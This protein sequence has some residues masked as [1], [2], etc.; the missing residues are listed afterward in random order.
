MQYDDNATVSDI[1]NGP[2]V[3]CVSEGT[4][5]PGTSLTYATFG[6]YNAMGQPATLTLGNGVQ[7]TYSYATDSGGAA[8]CQTGSFRLCTIQAT[9]GGSTLQNLAYGYDIE[10]NVA[11]VGHTVGAI[12]RVGA[13]TRINW[14]H[15]SAMEGVTMR[16]TKRPFPLRGIPLLLIY[17][18][19]GFNQE[20]LT[21]AQGTVINDT[22]RGNSSP[23]SLSY[24]QA[25][26]TTDAFLWA[27]TNRDAEI[28]IRLM[29]ERL[30]KS[31]KNDSWFHQYMVG[32]SDPHH[33][34]FELGPGEQLNPI[35]YEFRVILYEASNGTKEGFKYKGK[36]RV[37]QQGQYWRIDQLPASSEPQD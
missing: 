20:S 25:L 29:S 19:L 7:T 18:I 30:L 26:Q 21:F 33:F 4:C 2:L 36:L 3:N 13:T 23:I 15:G 37:I 1:Y 32:L 5:Q 28:G 8:F 31:A 22:D 27:W 6:G 34:A 24:L 16:Q 9:S 12:S 14:K 17:F 10:G 35:L 11:A